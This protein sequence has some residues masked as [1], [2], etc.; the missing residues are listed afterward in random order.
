MLVAPRHAL[1]PG[2]SLLLLGA[3][4]LSFSVR[5]LFSGGTRCWPAICS[6]WASWAGRAR[7]L[8]HQGAGRGHG[9]TAL[10]AGRGAAMLAGAVFQRPPWPPSTAL[11]H[12]LLA[13]KVYLRKVWMP[14]MM[15]AVLKTVLLVI[16]G[17]VLVRNDKITSNGFFYLG[18]LP[19]VSFTYVNNNLFTFLSSLTANG[20]LRL[21]STKRRVLALYL[22]LV[23]PALLADSLLSV[24]LML[25]LF[26]A[27]LWYLLGLW[28]LAAAALLNWAYGPAST[29]PSLS[30]KPSTLP[31]CATTPLA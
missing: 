17:L 8:L 25:A 27:S 10:A 30:S 22:R 6:T 4:V 14:L 5:L 28:P 2:F 11:A 16:A 26:P 20:L 29:R 3:T 23:L 18:L 7:S 24:A 15:S 1:I 9:A 21:G 12:L 13:W 31:I 19:I